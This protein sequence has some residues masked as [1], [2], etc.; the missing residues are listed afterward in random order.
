MDALVMIEEKNIFR[1]IF[2]KI[3]RNDVLV[4]VVFK[5][6]VSGSKKK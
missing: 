5:V 1:V 2:N 6:Y 4:F 3:Q